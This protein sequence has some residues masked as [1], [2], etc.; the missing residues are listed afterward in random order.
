MS[1]F[2][3]LDIGGT[4]C[5]AAAADTDGKIIRRTAP[6]QTPLSLD[7][8]L[9]MLHGMVAELA[10]TGKIEG[11]GAAIGGP[12]AWKTG[13][14][15]PLHQP[16]W[17]KVPLQQ[18]MEQRWGCPFRVE[19]DTDAAALGEYS[20]DPHKPTRFFYMTVSTGVGGGFLIDG[21]IYRGHN[22]AHPEAGHQ[23]VPFRCS[24]PE[25]VTCEC[26]APDCLEALVSG[27]GIR[28]V[29]DKP[30]ENLTEAEWA[31]VTWN[32][33]QG[34]RNV[35]AFYAPEVIALGGGVATGRGRRLIDE[36]KAVLK[37]HVRLVPLP[38]V[39]LSK[40]GY[41]TALY[42]ALTLAWMGKKT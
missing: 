11:I 15:S 31:E 37:N 42:G 36:V 25:K 8:G 13:V 17:R 39:R 29:Y 19:V 16:Q 34:L 40:L 7:E 4:K 21:N 22:S 3:G 23:S 33:A 26:G 14:V 1:I 20:R 35:A 5:M 12:L 10:G 2:I 41:D 27:N 38:V 28:R 32:L 30:A 6:R 9:E 18:I 24:H